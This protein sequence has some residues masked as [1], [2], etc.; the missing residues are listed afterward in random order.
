MC[1][2]AVPLAFTRPD[3]TCLNRRRAIRSSAEY[4]FWTCPDARSFH[5]YRIHL[6]LRASV[7]VH[8]S[9]LVAIKKNKMPFRDGGIISS[10]YPDTVLLEDISLPQLLLEEFD[11]FGDETAL[12]G[13]RYFVRVVCNKFLVYK[14]ALCL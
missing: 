8:Q 12:V 1:G 10:F 14:Q 7:K 5:E 2:P 9:V 4:F 11:R 6:A 13:T 3:I